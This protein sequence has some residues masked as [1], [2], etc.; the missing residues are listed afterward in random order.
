[1]RPVNRLGLAV[2]TAAVT[3]GLPF[4]FLW[5]AALTPFSRA[6]L[7]RFLARLGV[8]VGL[9]DIP[10][11]AIWLH[12]AS[13][14]E[15]KACVPIV[16]A[17][18]VL[19]PCPPIVVSC[20]TWDGM[21]MATEAFGPT[22]VAIFAPWDHPAV[23]GLFYRTLRPS[24]VI[25]AE[26]ELWPHKFLAARRRG[27][28]LLLVNG[29][30]PPRDYLRYRPF[31]F[32]FRDVLASVSLLGTQSEEDA[33]RFK[34]LGAPPSRVLEVGST[35]YDV[36][37][38]CESEVAGARPEPTEDPVVAVGSSHRGEERLILE[39]LAAVAQDLPNMQVILAPRNPRR[40]PAVARKARLR[41]F[42]PVVGSARGHTSEAFLVVDRMGDLP[43][44]Y[45]AARVAV[46]GG[47]FLDSVQGHNPLEAA[48]LGRP[49]IFGPCMR[50]F[51][52]VREILLRSGGALEARNGAELAEFLRRLLT[53]AG[54]AT[55]MGRAAREAVSSNQG[56]ALRYGALLRSFCSMKP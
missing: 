27:I 29:R 48:A 35:K 28:P 11:G 13:A 47:S 34:G 33:R 46:V 41:G 4:L 56:A 42:S 18:S 16:R 6:P 44:A 10:P 51:V 43:L 19:G 22:A 54:E 36:A 7:K 37:S 49:V 3:A 50:H 31:T 17:L 53:D 32:F 14:G 40:A 24:V 30:M 20:N 1:M 8:G 52:D 39:A 25:V 21:A 26:I 2:Y 9:A 5:T 55:R 38:H 45:A 23:V 12:A 15:I